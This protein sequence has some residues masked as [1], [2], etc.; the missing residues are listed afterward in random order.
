MN[1]IALLLSVLL[2][3]GCN[4]TNESQSNIA[5]E[6]IELG[7]QGGTEKLPIELPSGWELVVPDD[8][9]WIKSDCYEN[10]ADS[11]DDSKWITLIISEN[12]TQA[13]RATTIIL[14]PKSFVGFGKSRYGS[15]KRVN[16]VQH[17][18][19]TENIYNLNMNM[20]YVEGGTF[21]MGSAGSGNVHRVTLDSY[22]IGQTE[23][24]QAQWR[25][26]MGSNPSEYV[27]DSRPVDHISW[28]DA[29][30]FCER[31]SDLTGR[32]YLLPT[33]AQ[34]EYAARGGNKSKG[35]I[36]S[37]SNYIE[38][39]AKYGSTSGGHSNVKSKMPNELGIY[40]MSGNVWEWCSDLYG[41]TD[42]VVRGG[43]WSRDAG[44]CTVSYRGVNAPLHR[45][46][47]YGFRVVCLCGGSQAGR[48]DPYSER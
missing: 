3:V 44:G 31:L 40:D 18:G 12:N 27:G 37:G 33:E 22:Y 16:I 25:A 17:G 21:S 46:S 32:Q 1:I 29:Q 11:K 6:N 45:G 2:L 26:I 39:V 5:T 35:Y 23:V 47:S 14:R 13:T 10:P 19:L 8:C 38:D 43:S 42:R 34:W 7:S 24:T 30:A 15:I 41:R 20:I 48:V 9:T 36:Y 28:A 4:N